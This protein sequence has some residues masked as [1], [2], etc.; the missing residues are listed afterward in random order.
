VVGFGKEVDDD[1]SIAIV[2][3]N[4]VVASGFDLLF[5]TEAT[6][7]KP[8]ACNLLPNEDDRFFLVVSL[9]VFMTVDIGFLAFFK[10]I[11]DDGVCIVFLFLLVTLTDI[12]YLFSVYFNLN[13]KE[14]ERERKR[15]KSWKILSFL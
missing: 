5:D 2:L 6:R 1:E 9:A 15:E 10:K 13:N 3:F 8:A 14:R 4:V 7:D 12:R 11:D